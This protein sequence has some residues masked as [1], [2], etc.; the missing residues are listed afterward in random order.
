[1]SRG[2]RVP[3]SKKTN[4]KQGYELLHE[5]ADAPTP[6]SS[7]SRPA[8]SSTSAGSPK[9]VDKLG[10]IDMVGDETV[11]SHHRKPG[12]VAAAAGAGGGDYRG[13]AGVYLRASGT[14]WAGRR[15]TTRG[16]GTGCPTAT[17]TAPATSGN[18][19]GR[20]WQGAGPGARRRPD[21]LQGVITALGETLVYVGGRTPLEYAYALR[22]LAPADHA[23]RLP[24]SGVGTGGGY[25]GEQLT[26]E[27]K[28]FLQAVA[29]GRSRPTSR[30]TR[31]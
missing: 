7:S 12:R 30:S 25:L 21:K 26:A 5:D 28:G 10:G 20:S 4:V 24:G 2:S 31:S 11:K 15:S 16:S 3:G 13:P 6:G 27:G 9:L 29:K 8:R 14:S 17:T 1:M 23:G 22:N 19:C 18:W